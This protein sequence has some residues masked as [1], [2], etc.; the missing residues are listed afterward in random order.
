MARFKFL[1]KTGGCSPSGTFSDVWCRIVDWRGMESPEIQIH[2]IGEEGLEPG[3]SMTVLLDVPGDYDPV[4]EIEVRTDNTPEDS[5]WLLEKIEV[6]NLDT[7][8]ECSFAFNDNSSAGELFSTLN[9]V[10]HRRT[11]P[12]AEVFWCARDLSVYP[13]QNHHFLAI[14]FRNR[15]AAALMYPEYLTDT[16]PVN[17]HYFMTLGGYAEGTGK[18]MCCQ[19][20]QE[21]DADTFRT[22]LNTGKFFGSWYDMDYERHLIQP[23]N[24]K[25]E[26]ELA[27]SII[28]AG[29]CFMMHENRP[30]ACQQAGN[31][32]TFVNSLLAALGYSSGYRTERGT[33]W[34][35]PC[36]ENL[37]DISF[38]SPP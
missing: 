36:E 24:G 37:M 18:M 31:C 13:D 35:A 15:N 21:D 11:A 12:A 16:D 10:V 4:A 6:T 23:L 1:V 32:A 2:R 14:M 17:G 20:N 38:F 30:E 9:E 28:R 29:K 22:Y 5:F 19:F 25:S 27:E 34:V 3:T 26:L 8:D 7:R 33:F